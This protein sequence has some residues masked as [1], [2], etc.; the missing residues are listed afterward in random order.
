MKVLV[1]GLPRTGTQSLA[2][3]LVHLG[4]TPIY[5][6]REVAKNKHQAL[7]IQAMDAK[8]EGAGAPWNRDDFERILAGFEGVADY[9]AAIFPAELAA[10]YLEA[11]IILSIRSE[12]KWYDSMEST[13]VH[14][15]K[16]RAPD[17]QAPMAILSRKYHHHCWGDDFAATG[18]AFFQKHNQLVRDL[19]K[20]RKFLEWQ[21]QDGWAP[22]C[23]FLGV[24]TP[25][26]STPFP[27]SDDWVEYKKMVEQEK[28]R[29]AAKSSTEAPYAP[30]TPR[31]PP[32]NPNIP[33]KALPTALGAITADAAA[34]QTRSTIPHDL[35]S[36][37]ITPR[38]AKIA[39]FQN[40]SKNPVALIVIVVVSVVI[41]LIISI[42]AFIW[43]RKWRRMKSAFRE[44]EIAADAQPIY[45]MGDV[46]PGQV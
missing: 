3:G 17:D 40:N 46:P 22:L 16:T 10:A 43:I 35:L 14:L 20:G 11:P 23:S 38:T 6:M 2:D 19:G 8:F 33:L 4:I 34:K 42:F 5:H 32:G 18:R 37:A 30:S 44:A 26:E 29:L 41:L 9:P 25:P 13:L 21:P 31:P 27:R 28:L 1:L 15:Q 24:D 39:S 45:P 36:T 12:D 7:W